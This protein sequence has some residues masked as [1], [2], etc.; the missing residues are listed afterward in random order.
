MN[1]EQRCFQSV[2]P[3]SARS[4]SSREQSVFQGL[5]AG[6]AGT[7]CKHSQG[8]YMILV[9]LVLMLDHKAFP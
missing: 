4:R 7:E 3:A 9:S 8:L 1:V 5:S 2:G 6:K